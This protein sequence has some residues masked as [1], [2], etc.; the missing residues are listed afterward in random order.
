VRQRNVIYAHKQ[1]TVTGGVIQVSYNSDRRMISHNAACA[2]TVDEDH[3]V[4][5][6]QTIHNTSPYSKRST[7]SE[8]PGGPMY[9]FTGQISRQGHP[10]PPNARGPARTIDQ[11]GA[12][13]GL[14]SII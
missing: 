6:R 13:L 3:T 5:L 7:F 14:L 11:K 2:Y 12:L 10:T 1:Q 8:S 4:G 9:S